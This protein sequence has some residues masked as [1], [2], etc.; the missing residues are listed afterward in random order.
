MKKTYDGLS[1]EIY[2]PE[3][4]LDCHIEQKRKVLIVKIPWGPLG[5]WHPLG[6]AGTFSLPTTRRFSVDAAPA[7]WSRTRG[8][9]LGRRRGCG[10]DGRGLG[11]GGNQNGFGLANYQC[12]RGSDIGLGEVFEDT[13][14]ILRF[15]LK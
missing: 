14:N 12:I 4:L 1:F 13:G 10:Q 6:R 11:G 7:T 15:N 3:T 2:C 5:D 8:V 9:V